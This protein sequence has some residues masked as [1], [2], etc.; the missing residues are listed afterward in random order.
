MSRSLIFSSRR[1]WFCAVLALL[2][3]LPGCGGRKTVY[4]ASGELFVDGKPAPDAF[5]YLHPV[6]DSD[7][8]MPRPFAQADEDGHYA[9]SSYISGDGAP[10]GEY[11]VTFEWRERSGFTKQN[12]DGPDRLKGQYYDVKKSDYRVKIEKKANVLPHFDLKRP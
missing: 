6:E 2:L 11:I 5:I 8:T 7:P 12:F 4:P 3:L 9:L 10:A 1:R